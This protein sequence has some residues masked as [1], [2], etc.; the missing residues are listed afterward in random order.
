MRAGKLDRR[1]TLRKPTKAQDSYGEPL[2]TYA[3]EATVWAEVKPI[4]GGENYEGDQRS[5]KQRVEVVIRYR[6]GIE[7]NSWLFVYDGETYEIEDV[8]EM[9]RREGLKLIAYAREVKSGA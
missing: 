7:A 3:D 1:I 2:V 9:G 6:P 4:S 8:Q 5:S